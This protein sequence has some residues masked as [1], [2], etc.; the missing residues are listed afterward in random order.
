MRFKLF[1]I[2]FIAGL[3][4]SVFIAL[5]TFNSLFL[6]SLSWSGPYPVE[7]ETDDLEHIYY[8]TFRPLQIIQTDTEHYVAIFLWD[9]SHNYDINYLCESKDLKTWTSLRDVESI[10]PIN[11]ASPSYP[12]E[13]TQLNNGNLFFTR[14]IQEAEGYIKIGYRESANG[15]SWDSLKEAY[16]NLTRANILRYIFYHASILV[17]EE[18]T[19]T[20]Y[21][22]VE[23]A[24]NSY[25]GENRLILGHIEES[26]ETFIIEDI[27]YFAEDKYFRDCMLWNDK[28]T[29][30][31][32]K[33][34][35]VN[36]MGI[37]IYN[38]SQWNYFETENVD[39]DYYYELLVCEDVLHVIYDT[40]TEHLQIAE[41]DINYQD[42]SWQKT[43]TKTIT[44]SAFF[45]SV[46]DVENSN[47][48]AIIQTD[49]ST[50]I[51]YYIEEFDMSQL[52]DY[53]IKITLFLLVLV[54]PLVF[55]RIKE[56]RKQKEGKS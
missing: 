43:K 8:D 29:I 24:W 19:S 12:C 49:Y 17:F 33:Y 36:K 5:F 1:T 13:L 11:Y 48:K 45:R 26:N 35:D 15:E 4:V 32:E 44:Q 51:G 37:A 27:E 46:C 41:I 56:R 21:L 42:M 16:L 9:S 10:I 47:Q 30:L 2:K 18:G 6:Y 52:G 14:A 31:Y 7:F 28:P 22:L 23:D 50:L 3:S 54:I 40:S 55:N 20:K 39:D 25:Y 53:I 38:N 34:D